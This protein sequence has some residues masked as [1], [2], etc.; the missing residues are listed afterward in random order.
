MQCINRAKSLS[1]VKRSSVSC[2]ICVFIIIHAERVTSSTAT[3]PLESGV[4]LH[5]HRVHFLVHYKFQQLDAI[6]D[7][8]NIPVHCQV[9]G[10]VKAFVQPPTTTVAAAVA[11]VN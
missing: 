7:S 9:N 10:T 11:A 5:L 4:D 2:N 1:I 8:H 6:V 3:L